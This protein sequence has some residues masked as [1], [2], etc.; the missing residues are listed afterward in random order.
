MYC[1]ANTLG[2]KQYLQILRTSQKGSDN[3]A[4][5]QAS[6]VE[7]KTDKDKDTGFKTEKSMSDFLRPALF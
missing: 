5:A 4:N 2:Q 6:E 1:G 3:A 7:R